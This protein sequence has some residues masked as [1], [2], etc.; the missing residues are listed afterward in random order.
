MFFPVVLLMSALTH[1][2]EVAEPPM[3][4][5]REY[6]IRI[7]PDSRLYLEGSSNVNQFVC[8]CEQVFPSLTF[9]MEGGS[10]QNKASFLDTRLQLITKNLDCG[11]RGMNRDLYKTLKADEFPQIVFALRSVNPLPDFTN[12]GEQR[13][14]TEASLTIAGQSRPVDLEVKARPLGDQSFHFVSQKT[15]KMS[16]FGIEPPTALMGLIK[17]DDEITI[18]F[19]LKVGLEIEM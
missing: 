11:N 17:V 2:I 15:I 6:T 13:V 12:P 4:G 19:D 5:F 14:T 3:D 9:N 10:P 8:D 7:L 1:P 18:H 16:D